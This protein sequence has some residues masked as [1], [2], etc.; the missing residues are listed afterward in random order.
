MLVDVNEQAEEERKRVLL[1]VQSIFE[2]I[3]VG[4]LALLSN[5]WHAIGI[6]GWL[7]GITAGYFILKEAITLLGRI[8][9]SKLGRPSLVRETSTNNSNDSYNILSISRALFGDKQHSSNATAADAREHV[10]AYFQ[11]VV[12]PPVLQVRS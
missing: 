4:A 12:L 10:S 2:Y 3:S 1:T 9:S 6:A 11:D 7:L 5:P 8:V